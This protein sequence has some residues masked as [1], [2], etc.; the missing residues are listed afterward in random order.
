MHPPFAFHPPWSSPH[1]NSTH[2]TAPFTKELEIYGLSLRQLSWDIN[3]LEIFSVD[4]QG[5][6]SSFRMEQDLAENVLGPGP[7]A[8][9]KALCEWMLP[10]LLAKGAETNDLQISYCQTTW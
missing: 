1:L 3:A 8:Q 7:E 6:L 10:N 2:S 5:Y 4:S 9:A